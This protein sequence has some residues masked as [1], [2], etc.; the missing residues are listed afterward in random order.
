M[1][2]TGIIGVAEVK[3]KGYPVNDKTD[4]GNR[5][6]REAG[7]RTVKFTVKS[8]LTDLEDWQDRMALMEIYMYLIMNTPI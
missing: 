8:E 6:P 2:L 5:P 3:I 7:V 4:P 1:A